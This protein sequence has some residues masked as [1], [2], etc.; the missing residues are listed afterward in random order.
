MAPLLTIEDQWCRVA[1]E[2]F[3]HRGKS[4]G[5]PPHSRTLA[6]FFERI[7]SREASWSAPVLSRSGLRLE[8]LWT[9]KQIP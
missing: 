6:R 4:G 3:A 2:T 1:D 7:E 8:S 5:G 9:S